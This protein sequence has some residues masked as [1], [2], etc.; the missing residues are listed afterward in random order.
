MLQFAVTPE[1]LYVSEEAGAQGLVERGVLVAVLG[2]ALA[3]GLA[4]LRGYLAQ[5]RRAT[6]GRRQPRR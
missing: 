1:E 5:P 3:A 6:V 2:A 4:R